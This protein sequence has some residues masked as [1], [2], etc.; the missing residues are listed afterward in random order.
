MCIF[1]VLL[2]EIKLLKE[3]PAPRRQLNKDD[4]EGYVGVNVENDKAWVTFG[5][6][7]DVKLMRT[8]SGQLSI[9]AKKVVTDGT[10]SVGG[11]DLGE[12]LAKHTKSIADITS[13]I[14]DNTKG[15][16]YDDKLAAL[17]D[18]RIF[19]LIPG[20]K[21]KSFDD[22]INPKADGTV[23]T[24]VFKT[25]KDGTDKHICL[26][27]FRFVKKDGTYVIPVS[28]SNKQ[29]GKD[30]GNDK[31]KQVFNVGGNPTNDADSHWCAWGLT[32]ITIN[33]KEPTAIAF[34]KFTPH[35]NACT[36]DPQHWQILG[37]A[38][39]GAEL[40]LIGEENTKCPMRY[41]HGFNHFTF[42]WKPTTD[43]PY[44]KKVWR[45]TVTRD[46]THEHICLD[47]FRF[48]MADGKYGVPVAVTNSQ[49]GKDYGTDKLKPV[50]NVGGSPT[51]NGK[52][53]WCAWGLTTI[54][55]TFAQPV[56]VTA[57]KFIPHA[58]ACTNDP[59][60]WY[61]GAGNSATGS[62]DT[63][64]H[65]NV[66]CPL[67]S[68]TSWNTYQIP[69]EGFYR[70][71]P[72]EVPR[73]FKFWRWVTTKD[74]TGAHICLDAFR[75]VKPN[76]KGY[77]IPIKVTNKQGGQD[78]GIS[79]LQ[80]VVNYKGSRTNDGRS[81]WCAWAKTTITFEFSGPVTF[82]SYKFVPHSNPC[83]NDPQGWDIQVGK[84]RKFFWN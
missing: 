76:G 70:K 8:G 30:Y 73:G 32:T 38:K 48:I 59:Q 62:F 75:F 72:Y 39:D 44:K 82:A 6:D 13:A 63:V 27:N 43:T 83:S 42:Q 51:N 4:T 55:V 47:A 52:S 2:S 66:D 3:G 31:L 65:E 80:Q 16:S 22:L 37:R 15:R 78:Y 46:G 14:V 74:G 5:K 7:D 54:S 68:L 11:K 12:S 60:T 9:A 64:A 58:N 19:K 71:D 79:K 56:A 25:L 21:D 45:M 24:I 53:H 28:V 49:A 50:F 35:G 23:K 61:I 77:G 84:S 10:L 26:D 17:I 20:L 57:Y 36:N 81:H 41:L 69:K 18:A 67:P 40:Q 29:S 1:Q 33:F 34:Y